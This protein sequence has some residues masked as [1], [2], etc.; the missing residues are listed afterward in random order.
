MEKF[1]EL[2][3]ERAHLEENSIVVTMMMM[4]ARRGKQKALNSRKHK[5]REIVF[6]LHSLNDGS[7]ILYRCWMLAD[8]VLKLLPRI[9]SIRFR[10]SAR[11][12]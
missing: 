3:L 4:M 9:N 5:I 8:K 10:A 6:F 11:G 7:C 1:S 12:N 2:A